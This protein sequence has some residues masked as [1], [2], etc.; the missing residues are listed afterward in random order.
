M[1]N[2]ILGTILGITMMAVNSMALD[3]RWKF[4][5]VAEEVRFY[6]DS[7]TVATTDKDTVR[8]W[9]TQVFPEGN[10]V[11]ESRYLNEINCTKRTIRFI[12]AHI[13]QK[14]GKNSISNKTSP[15]MNI[16]PDTMFE[17]FYDIV[18]KK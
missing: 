9:T 12:Q 2:I 1:P 8:F 3:A 4:I 15:V 10:K 7:L 6:Y 5:G 18:C 16:A 14:D 13:K 17:K 11:A